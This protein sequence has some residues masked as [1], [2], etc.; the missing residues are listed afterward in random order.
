MGSIRHILHINRNVEDVKSAILEKDH[1]ISW[2]TNDITIKDIESNK[3]EFKFGD[4]SATALITM[5]ANVIEWKYID[6][7][8]EM[9]IGN[10]LTFTL[11]EKENKTRVLAEQNGFDLESDICAN[12]NFSLGKYLE[13][14]RQ[15]L[16][17]GNK[18]GWGCE[19][20]RS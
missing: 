20:Y 2:Y 5:D 11:E 12:F 4:I 13:S 6:S 17:Y 10:S 3:M 14:L 8:F 16:Q 19:D 15:Y 1:L 9:L 7:T 18:E